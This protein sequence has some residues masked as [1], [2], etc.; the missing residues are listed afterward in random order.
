ME[1]TETRYDVDEGVAVI[2]LDRPDKLNAWTGTMDEEV[3]HCMQQ[4][5]ADEA[6][7]VIVLTGAGRG[8]CARADMNN[9]QGIQAGGSSGGAS[10]QTELIDRRIE[11]RAP[12]DFSDRYSYFPSVPKPVIG[13]INGPTAG[14]GMVI[15]MFCD[16]RIWSE[17]ARMSTVFARRGLVAEYGLTWMLQRIVGPAT[18]AEMLFSARFVEA[19]EALRIGIANAVHPQASFMDDV[20]AYAKEMA[21]TVSPRSLRVMKHQLWADAF[22]S[23]SESIARS[24]QEMVA[25]F[26]SEDFAEG[27]AHYV[28]KRA[29]NFTGR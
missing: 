7:R 6:V 25:S 20:L 18:A 13:A 15:A 16:F 3:Y 12:A 4:A 19:E 8:F 27:V 22:G 1:L 28:E 21:A 10:M 29:P 23:L 9:L 5:S 14:L 11:S 26:D 2:T 17:T 24:K